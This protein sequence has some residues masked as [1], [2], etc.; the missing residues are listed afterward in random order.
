MPKENKKR[1][2]I[3]GLIDALIKLKEY[4]DE[5]IKEREMIIAKL[6]REINENTKKI[7]EQADEIYKLKKEV[8]RLKC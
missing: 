8:K 5:A 7:M 1:E 2:G 6:N 3:G 4:I